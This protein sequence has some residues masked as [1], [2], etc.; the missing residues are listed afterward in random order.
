MKDAAVGFVFGG[1]RQYVSKLMKRLDT[2]LR[3]RFRLRI[4]VFKKSAMLAVIGKVCTSRVLIYYMQRVGYFKTR[5]RSMNTKH[6][7]RYVVYYRVS[8]AGQGRSGLGLE[9]QR[10]AV[11]EQDTERSE[12][13][14]MGSQATESA[15]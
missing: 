10:Q 4:K 12:R 7:G 8:T 2:T 5:A 1:N 15:G 13:R 11:G 6:F 3:A 14:K 9:A